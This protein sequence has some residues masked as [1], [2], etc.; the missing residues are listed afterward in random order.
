[1]KRNQMSQEETAKE[2]DMSLSSIEKIA[3]GRMKLRTV[4][5]YALMWL[6]KK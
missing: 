4:V 1:M 6:E 5:K 2:L 3:N